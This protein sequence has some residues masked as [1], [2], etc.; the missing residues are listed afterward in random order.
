MFYLLL[1]RLVDGD[2]GY[3]CSAGCIVPA[4]IALCSPSP[5][6]RRLIIIQRPLFSIIFV[7][8]GAS[9]HL[10]MCCLSLAP[11]LVTVR[12][13]V[14]GFTQGEDSYE[15]R[16]FYAESVGTLNKIT[17]IRAYWAWTDYCFSEIHIVT[18]QM[19][20]TGTW[21]WVRHKDFAAEVWICIR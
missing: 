19:P 11:F 18:V 8:C 7:H 17:L 13:T 15:H 21:F 10:K 9:I 16:L 4:H 20:S 2:Y 14:L 3:G 5:A 6:I 1:R 12:C